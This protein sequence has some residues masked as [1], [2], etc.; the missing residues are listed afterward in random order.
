MLQANNG[1]LDQTPPSAACGLGLHYLPAS[2]KKDDILDWAKNESVY[3]SFK[4][5]QILA[6]QTLNVSQ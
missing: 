6:N 2:H 5:S 1:E 4:M 3:F